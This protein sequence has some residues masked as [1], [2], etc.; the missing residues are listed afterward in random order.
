MIPKTFQK[1]AQGG[2]RVKKKENIDY[3]LIWS[4]QHF[5][6]HVEREGI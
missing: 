3:A 2:T 4:A 1:V 5:A 6:D